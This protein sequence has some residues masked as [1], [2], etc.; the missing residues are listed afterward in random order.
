MAR[1]NLNVASEEELTEI[2]GVDAQLALALVE[3][4]RARA[5]FRS[6]DDVR[7][8][9][10]IDDALFEHLKK[11]ASLAE[12]RGDQDEQQ[13][14]AGDV[15]GEAAVRRVMTEAVRR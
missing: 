3:S 2:E 13:G 10:G 12:D 8:V 14:V 4:R 6:W 9:G 7:A 1:I 15:S 5:G 11:Q